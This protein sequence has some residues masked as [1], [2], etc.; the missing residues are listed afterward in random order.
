MRGV[1]HASSPGRKVTRRPML[2][3]FNFFVFSRLHL[4]CHIISYTFFF[5][6]FR[7]GLF[8]L[9]SALFVF[10][11]LDFNAFYY[12]SPVIIVAHIHL[13]RSFPRF[14]ADCVGVQGLV[15]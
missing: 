5:S 6:F 14:D 3:W 4:F 2:R 10:S 1:R 15:T 13:S 7:R 8:S 11:L 9:P 12:H